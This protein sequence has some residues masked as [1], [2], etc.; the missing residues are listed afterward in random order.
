[1]NAFLFDLHLRRFRVWVWTGLGLYISLQPQ[2]G[3]GVMVF[4]G[5]KETCFRFFRGLAAGFSASRSRLGGL[6]GK[7]TKLATPAFALNTVFLE[8][9][10]KYFAGLVDGGW[11]VREFRVPAFVASRGFNAELEETILPRPPAHG[12]RE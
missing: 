11:D 7:V 10:S 12:E 2:R 5:E 8:N 6:Y 9:S 1:M 3:V 4:V